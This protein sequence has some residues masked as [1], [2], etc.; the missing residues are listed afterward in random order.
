M[1]QKVVD[2]PAEESSRQLGRVLDDRGAAD[3]HQE[4]DEINRRVPVGEG[5]AAHWPPIQVSPTS[6][7]RPVQV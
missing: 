4:K 6:A 3:D 5:V 2:R 7:P 1:Q